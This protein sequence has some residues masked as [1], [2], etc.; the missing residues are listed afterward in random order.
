MTI[1]KALIVDDSLLGRTSM[2]EAIKHL[3]CSIVEASNGLEALEKIEE[4]P[5]D[6]I[7][8][9]LLMPKMDGFD[10]LKEINKSN[11][12]IPVIIVSA[13][14]QETTK[15]QCKKEGVSGFLNKPVDPEE[16]NTLILN[17]SEN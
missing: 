3:N 12:K 10:F 15:A 13:D 9:D 6:L 4:F 2:K 1:S 16:L 17:L 8:L 5:P 14:I 11:K 7:F